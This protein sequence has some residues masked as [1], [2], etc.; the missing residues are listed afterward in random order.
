MCGPRLSPRHANGTSW[1]QE[2]LARA[3][4]HDVSGPECRGMHG[5]LVEHGTFAKT[6]QS[7]LRPCAR[8]DILYRDNL[9]SASAAICSGSRFNARLLGNV[10]PAPYRWQCH[11]P[12]DALHPRSIFFFFQL[13]QACPVAKT[14]N[15]HDAAHDAPPCPLQVGASPSERV[16]PVSVESLENLHGYDWAQ[17]PPTH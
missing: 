17:S 8:N 13:E 9:S 5:A 1:P 6:N 4:S 3:G 7:P 2:L 12:M 11:E 14:E 16:C 15:H 10:P